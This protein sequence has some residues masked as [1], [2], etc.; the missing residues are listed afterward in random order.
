MAVNWSSSVIDPPCRRPASGTIL[1]E[2]ARSVADAAK[3]ITRSWRRRAQFRRV[4]REVAR[5]PVA[6]RFPFDAV[7]SANGGSSVRHTSCAFQHRVWNRQAAG[8][9]NGLGTSPVSRIRSRFPLPP[10]VRAGHRGQQRDRVG[11]HRGVVDRVPLAELDD[12]AEVHDRD[13]V[14]DVAHHRQ[15][16]GDED[17][18]EVELGLQV[19]QQVHHLRLDRDVQ[20]GHRLV[21]DDQL[22]PQ[23]QGAGDADALALPAGE[24]VRVAVVVLGVEPDPRQQVLH[25]RL[26]TAGRVDALDA[27]RRGDD[28]AD[29][30]PRD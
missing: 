24:L 25:R 5:H 6:P 16:V 10:R 13:P 21:R 1:G 11:V 9:F 15:V 19:L 14:A 27:V 12:L 29:R 18:G 28:R 23:G 20:G 17:V 26:D 2:T 22:G 7:S 8:G 30:V 3:W 4:L